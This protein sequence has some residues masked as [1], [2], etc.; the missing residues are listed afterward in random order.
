MKVILS[1]EISVYLCGK[2]VTE[3]SKSLLKLITQINTER[4][5]N[6]KHK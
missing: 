6:D 1:F 3:N 5:K 4:L 2:K